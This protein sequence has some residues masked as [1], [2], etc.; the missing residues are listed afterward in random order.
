MYKYS[1]IVKG[2]ERRLTDCGYQ[3]TILAETFEKI[4]SMTATT[5]LFIVYLPGGIAEDAVNLNHLTH[6]H[7]TVWE[8]GRNM[9]LIGEK[10]D[11]TGLMKK[12]PHLENFAWLDRPVKMDELQLAVEA[13]IESGSKKKILIVDD[14]PSYAKMV[15][16]WI[17]DEYQPFSVT[18]G[19][20][21]ISFLLKT[22]VDLILLDYEMPVVDGPQVFQMLRQEPATRDIPV[23]FLTGVG[24]REGVERVMALKPDGYILKSTTKE[25]LLGYLGEKLRRNAD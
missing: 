21:A 7:D 4:K 22:P 2:I 20:N 1:V 6:I 17:R 16:E 3:V 15:R 13:A 9:L 24:T 8:S 10:K 12:H 23:V 14:D 11:R 19:M 25:K 18:G 5:S